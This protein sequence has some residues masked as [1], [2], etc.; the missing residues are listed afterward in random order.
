M[1]DNFNL[2][3]D[4]IQIITKMLIEEDFKIK[5]KNIEQKQFI[6]NPI[7][8]YKFCIKLLKI[9]KRVDEMEVEE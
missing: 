5:N 3:D 6:I 9:L 2:L 8:L 7:Q 4:S 1:D